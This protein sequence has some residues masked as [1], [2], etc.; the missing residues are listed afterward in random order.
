MKPTSSPPPSPP[1]PRGGHDLLGEALKK[2]PYRRADL[3]EVLTRWL[4]K[5]LLAD[6]YA[7]LE[8]AGQSPEGKIPLAQVFID[9]PAPVTR[10]MRPDEHASGLV[11]ELLRMEPVPLTEAAA[12]AGSTRGDPGDRPTHKGHFV[13]IGG[14]GQGKSTIGQYLCQIYRAA[15][16][17]PRAERLSSQGRSLVRVIETECDRDGLGAPEHPLLP[18]RIELGELAAWMAREAIP[19]ES[20]V[21]AFVARHIEKRTSTDVSPD[22]L[23]ALFAACPLFLV[24]DGLDEV[25]ASSGRAPMLDAISSFRR[26]LVA[27]GARGLVLATTR[28]QGYSGDFAR[29]ESRYLSPLSIE[30]ALEYAKRLVELRYY[31]QEDRRERILEDLAQARD[32][33][34]FKRLMQSPLQVTIMVALVAR[35][36]PLPRQRW[37]LFSKYYEILRDREME[38]RTPAAELL[39]DHK[40]HIETIHHRVGLLLQVESER[41]GGS[42]ALMSRE[43]LDQVVDAV[44]VGAGYDD[45]TRRDELREAIIDVATERLVFLVSP[46]DGQYG[47]ELRSLQEMMAAEALMSGGEEQIK[48]R[49]RQIALSD[50]WRGVFLFA[51]SKIYTEA[52][53][54]H[55]RGFFVD[56]CAELD[57]SP[58]D[59]PLRVTQAG[60]RLALEILEENSV[61][62]FPRYANPLSDRSLRLLDLPPLGLN[63]DLA[64]TFVRKILVSESAAEANVGIL[65]A[66]LD[67]AQFHAR[68]SAWTVLVSLLDHLSMRELMAV[69]DEKWPPGGEEQRLIVEAFVRDFWTVG[70]WLQ[71][72]I[73]ANL[74]N[75]EPALIGGLRLDVEPKPDRFLEA[76][77]SIVAGGEATVVFLGNEGDRLSPLPFLFN[78]LAS[79]SSEAW[80]NLVGLTD[81]AGVWPAWVAVAKFS[82]DPSASKLADALECIAE[83]T[84]SLAMLH[85][86][87]RAPWPIAACLGVAR[88]REAL[89]AAAEG[90]RLGKFG[91]VAQWLEAEGRWKALGITAGDLTYFSENESPFDAN[92]GSIGFPLSGSV[93]GASAVSNGVVGWLPTFLGLLPSAAMAVLIYTILLKLDELDTA[94][95]LGVDVVPAQRLLLDLSAK[96]PFNVGVLRPLLAHMRMSPEWASVVNEIGLG[97]LVCASLLVTDLNDYAMEKYAEDEGR[98]GLLRIAALTAE[99]LGKT[100]FPKEVFDPEEHEDL[101]VMVS[102]VRVR[103]ARVQCDAADIDRWARKIAHS[104]VIKTLL[105]VEPASWSFA[106]LRQREV[107]L[108]S[109]TR[110]IPREKWQ[111]HSSILKALADA[112]SRRATQIDDLTTWTRLGLPLPPPAPIPAP[113]SLALA[114]PEPGIVDV[115]HLEIANLRAFDTLVLDLPERPTIA[116]DEGRWLVILGENGTGKSTLL[117]SL[118]FA[119]GTQGITSAVLSSATVPFRRTGTD[120]GE[121]KVKTAN[122]TFRTRIKPKED[123]EVAEPFGDKIRHPLLFAYGCRRG[124]ALGGSQREVSFTP[125]GEVVTLFDEAEGLI[126]AETW[127]TKLRLAA[128]LGQE[129]KDDRPRQVFDTV[130]A[131][132]AKVLPGVLKIEVEADHVYLTGPAVGERVPLSALSDGY[133]T[134]LGWVIDLVAR[135]MNRRENVAP[136]AAGFNE[137][138]EGLVLVDELDLHLHP[139][140]Q[141]RVIDDLRGAF[142]R[143]SFVVTTHNP[144]TLLGARDGEVFILRRDGEGAPIRAEQRDL[145]KGLRADQVLTGPWFGLASTLDADTLA[146]LDEHRSLLRR[147]VPETDTG[148][149]GIEAVLRRRLGSF[150]ETSLERL[151]LQVAAELMEEE[152]RDL[153]PEER[154]ALKDKVKALVRKRREAPK[155]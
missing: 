138:M 1:R 64:M 76:V 139:R 137:I 117:R 58:E 44:L 95:P 60:G 110:Y 148:R 103:L 9:I 123:S 150:A 5:Q 83:L 108:T 114:G 15:L 72:K 53:H 102:D 131:V 24:L 37:A 90:A 141:V 130:L 122:Q 119:L 62:G 66:K 11:H 99:H 125:L 26:E 107:F 67:S 152:R 57:V 153:T 77:K 38:R 2:G 79:A 51:A 126:H 104:D 116:T 46:E 21:L 120:F 20:A 106:S 132:L 42:D 36:G 81:P 133:L 84:S 68:V 10:G 45:K 12:I 59:E 23:R 61:L 63:L 115:R 129:K 33:A 87:A 101:E 35:S 73:L 70:P 22:D 56:L 111:Y 50:A 18:V 82:A 94:V 118:V 40:A 98:L 52:S 74:A 92:V 136:I 127:L 48:S 89:R 69:G 28:P 112:I 88:D 149:Q 147:G 78:S 55:L 19:V 151:A 47:F 75:F 8:Q 16:L 124:S 93:L 27:M 85:I 13:L 31:D 30:R 155:H 4:E 96:L 100:D 6:Q 49:L 65:I 80:S 32:D 105:F 143:M 3:G 43:R 7:R 154:D 144:L 71:G 39:H 54:E 109:L 91:D 29:F 17:A 25:P 146:L 14:P 121:T 113:N 41:S 135:W 34:S 142:P 145:P 86:S 97:R 134:T 128:A 140:W